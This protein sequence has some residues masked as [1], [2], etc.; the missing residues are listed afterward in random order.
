MLAGLA[1]HSTCLASLPPLLQAHAERDSALD[2]VSFADIRVTALQSANADLQVRGGRLVC[3]CHAVEAVDGNAT[4]GCPG[5]HGC[6]EP[7]VQL[8]AGKPQPSSTAQSRCHRCLTLLRQPPQAALGNEQLRVMELQEAMAA[9]EADAREAARMQGEARA[10]LEKA[11]EQLIS[12]QTSREHANR[13]VCSLCWGRMEAG[14][15]RSSKAGSGRCRPCLQLCKPVCS[16]DLHKC[17][18]ANGMP[19]TLLLPLLSMCCCRRWRITTAS[20]R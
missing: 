13:K 1:T 9:R 2:Q 18:A 20:Q 4:T 12:A 3:K 16:Q 7:A 14:G 8:A 19:D 5:T 11:M 10:Q 15:W 6:I 17:A